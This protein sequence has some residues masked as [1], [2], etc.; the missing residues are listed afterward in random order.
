MYNGVSRGNP[1]QNKATKGGIKVVNVSIRK[2]ARKSGVAL[3]EL[4]DAL[5]F[6]EA[7]M[8]RKMRHEL[9]ESE[10]AKFLDAIETVAK[11]KNA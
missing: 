5:G 2:A 7:T 1:E 11:K 9:G 6:S 4:A 8:V 3:W 10:K